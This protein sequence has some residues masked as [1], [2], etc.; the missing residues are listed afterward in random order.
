MSFIRRWLSGREQAQWSHTLSVVSPIMTAFDD[1]KA[2]V[3]LAFN[4]ALTLQGVFA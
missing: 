3:E 2:L 1:A 4:H